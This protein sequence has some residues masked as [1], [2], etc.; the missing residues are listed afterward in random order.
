MAQRKE[1]QQTTAEQVTGLCARGKP[2]AKRR[3]EERRPPQL[4]VPGAGAVRSQHPCPTSGRLHMPA[5]ETHP[6]AIIPIGPG[7][8]ACSLNPL[9]GS[10]AEPGGPWRQKGQLRALMVLTGGR[11]CFPGN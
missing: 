1:E 11:L 5:L 4:G 3:T 6:F 10:H 8:T 7:C 9:L 2:G